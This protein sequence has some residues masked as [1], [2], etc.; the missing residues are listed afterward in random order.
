[1]RAIQRANRK[2]VAI[3]AVL[4]SGAALA[5][6]SPAAAA[7]Y[8]STGA[9]TGTCCGY[10][11]SF[12]TASAQLTTNQPST[13]GT[14]I[15]VDYSGSYGSYTQSTTNTTNLTAGA[16]SAQISA[17]QG[18]SAAS[19]SASLLTGHVTATAS[20][21]DAQASGKFYTDFTVDN[22]TGQNVYLPIGWRVE[23]NPLLG[24]TSWDGVSSFLIFDINGQRSTSDGQLTY[25]V[26]PFNT[27]AVTTGPTNGT[28]DFNN[29]FSV[30]DLGGYSRLLS[31]TIEISPGVSSGTIIGYLA[32]DCRSGAVCDYGH[33]GAL[34][35]G[36]ASGVTFSFDAPGFL[37]GGGVPEP[38][39]WAVMLVGL[40]MAGAGSRLKRR[41]LAG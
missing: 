30:T 9:N 22:T 15:T 21:V 5:A 25:G 28:P 35:L 11:G 10:E 41:Q 27:H 2:I 14:G 32:L 36:S 19:G 6:A 12:V 13:N 24:T 8:I 33:T 39:S 16:V 40:G 29:G 18:A 1:M 26:D 4:S 7:F 3:C 34:S 31:D 20:G 37:T 23:G 38:A 17:G